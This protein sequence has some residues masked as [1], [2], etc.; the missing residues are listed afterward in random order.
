[1]RS[2]MGAMVNLESLAPLTTIDLSAVLNIFTQQKL[3]G[4]GAGVRALAVSRRRTMTK[5]ARNATRF[6]PGRLDRKYLAMAH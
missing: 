4:N 1:M 2:E 6:S 5:P 3:F